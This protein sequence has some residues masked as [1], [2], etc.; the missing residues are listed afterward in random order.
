[1]SIKLSLLAL[2]SEGPNY[3]YQLKTEFEDRTGGAWPLN[4]GQVYTTLERLERD[5]LVARA[6][7]D[8][9]GR[10]GY[11]ITGRGR[12]TVAEWFTSGVGHGGP[13][14]DELT[15]KLALAVTLP[16]IDVPGLIQAQR[17]AAVLLLQDLSRARRGATEIPVRLMLESRIYHTEAELR[18]LDHCEAAVLRGVRPHAVS[19]MSARAGEPV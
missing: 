18:W 11:E 7:I 4:I 8:F 15:V 1:M 19:S 2:L 16:G 3:G 17:K 10:A 14:R 5:G 6:G 12:D 13:V 9:E